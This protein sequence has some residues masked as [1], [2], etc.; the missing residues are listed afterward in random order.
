MPNVNDAIVDCSRLSIWIV[1]HCQSKLVEWVLSLVDG[2]SFARDFLSVGD[3]C[4]LR[5]FVRPVDAVHVTAGPDEVHKPGPDQ[6][7]EL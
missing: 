2:S 3:R 7:N 5:S 4:R 6:G 1:G